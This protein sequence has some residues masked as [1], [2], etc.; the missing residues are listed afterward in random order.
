MTLDIWCGQFNIVGGQVQEEGPFTGVFEGTQQAAGVGLYVVAEPIGSATAR[1]CNDALEVIARAFGSPEQAL[2]AN[3]LRAI[4]AGHRHAQD[5]NR[6]HAVDRAAGVGLSC[7]ATRG[8]E[9]YLAQCGPALAVARTGGRVR[10]AAPTGDDSRRPLGLGERAAPV[11]TRFSLTP[12]DVILLTS[13]AADRLIDRG[14]LINLVAAP[15]EEAMPA[16]YMHARSAASFAALYLAVV[17]RAAPVAAAAPAL[18][19]RATARDRGHASP[20]PRSDKSAAPRRGGRPAVMGAA[21]KTTGTPHR[22]GREPESLQ[23]T[24]V[25]QAATQSSAA[26]R[27]AALAALAGGSRL[28]SRRTMLLAAVAL[29]V[30]LLLWLAIPALA[31]RGNDDHYQELLHT[32]DDALATAQAEPDAGRRRTLLN[33]AEADLLEARTIRPAAPEV[34][35]RLGQVAAA[36]AA[37]DGARELTELAPVADLTDAGVAPQTP[38]ELVVGARIYLLDADA[39]RVLAFSG[40]TG[41]RP[42][43]VFEEGRSVGR[44]RTGKARHLALVPDAAGRA[45]TL[46]VLDANRRL[47]ALTAEGDWRPV[48][49]PGADAWKAD[50]AMA[51]TVGALYVL[52]APGE[53]IWRYTG[54]PA[55]YDGRPE[56]VMTGPPL[57]AAA[58]LS[59]SGVPVVATTDGRLL[60]MLEGRDEEL[61]PAGLDRP[62]AAPS[63][64]IFNPADGLLYIADRGNRRIV[65]LD[66]AGTFQGQLVHR[67]LS[68]LRALTLDE[69]HGTLYA[70]SGQALVKAP[71][72]R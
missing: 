25:V 69:A 61:R 70:V 18:G 3:L 42:E 20:P 58:E 45:G 5:W 2:T 12:G 49:L 23:G 32:A 48:A 34:A 38:V 29:G 15:P 62:F 39:G 40:Q 10:V 43:V 28:P 13:S 31:R 47:F 64:P 21:R 72:P 33:H 1:L 44:E 67:R 9:A 7:L 46:L 63:A 60:R 52:D 14:T 50:T 51:A 41:E 8:D 56:P 37:I 26:R 68:A 4:S 27:R 53:R 19:N 65:L 66:A 30:L 11:F 59:I 6:L 24:R 16:L 36:L 17:E 57:R 35:D 55:G 22:N 54:T 71:L